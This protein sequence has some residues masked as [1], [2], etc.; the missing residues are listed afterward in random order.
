MVQEIFDNGRH[1][2]RDWGA[3]VLNYTEKSRHGAKEMIRRFS[4]Q[5]LDHRTPDTPEI[6]SKPKFK[7]MKLTDH[8]SE[9]VVAPDCS[10]T[11][12]ATWTCVRTSKEDVKS[13][14]LTPVRTSNHRIIGNGSR[15][16]TGD[17]KVGELYT[18]IFIS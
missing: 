2:F 15:S 8:M 9:A 5:E 17:S 11:S 7:M 12:G 13:Y 3:I 14:L 18:P 4:F 6:E 16:C 1:P 10:M